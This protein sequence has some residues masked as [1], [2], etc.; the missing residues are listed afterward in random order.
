MDDHDD[1][2][3]LTRSHGSFLRGLAQRLCRTQL[4]PDDLVQ[5]V[6]ERVLTHPAPAGVNERAWLARIT[7]NLFID[8]LRRIHTRRE[9]LHDEIADVAPD[10]AA[11]WETLTEE[12]VRRQ[13][14]TLPEPLRITFERFVIHGQSYEQIARALGIAKAT[15]G[16]RILRART[17]LRELLTG[18]ASA[19][20][21]PQPA[22]SAR[23]DRRQ[24][25]IRP[26][27]LRPC[28]A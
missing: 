14:A 4:D 23:E 8:K 25:A 21:E 1:L 22:R 7:R 2:A 10:E 12:T 16:T 26:G 24:S 18:A 6:L 28:H 13:L 5:D 11:W 3:A 17:R 19:E 20:S 9:D 27:R 15:V